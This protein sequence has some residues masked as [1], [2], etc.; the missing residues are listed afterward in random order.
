MLKLLSAC[1]VALSLVSS[2]ALAQERFPPVPPSG[3]DDAQKKAAEEFLAVRK[4][5]VYGP[6]AR[7]MHSP[8]LMTVARSMGD[9]LRFKSAVGTTLSELVILVTAREWAQDYE[10]DVHAPIALQQGIKKEIV[11]A[12]R[13]GRRPTG[14][15]D[16]E[17]MCY[18]FSIELHRNKSVS[19]ATYERVA[20]RFGQKG[21]VDLIGINGYYTFLAM[22]MNTDR[23][24]ISPE[25]KKLP[26]FPD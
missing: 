13:D 12:I 2:T 24:P 4:R 18:E 9:H 10:W 11:D 1:A 6:F 21:V 14:M 20:K 7:L 8:E 23:M 26:R 19:D 25:R 16:D 15:S 22:M 5:P 3:Y 17:E